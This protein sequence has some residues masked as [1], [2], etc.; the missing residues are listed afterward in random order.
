MP[1]HIE[2]DM[3]DRKQAVQRLSEIYGSTATQLPLGI[4]IRLVSGFREVKGNDVVM[5]KHV[6][7]RVHQAQFSHY[8]V[9]HLNNTIMLLG[10]ESDGHTLRRSRVVKK[11]IRKYS[12]Y[13]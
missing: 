5:G 3:E 9:G 10:Y 4:R 7:L 2:V 8:T 13:N 1:I 11:K 12:P 6:H